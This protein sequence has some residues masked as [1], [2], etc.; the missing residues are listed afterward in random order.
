[1]SGRS[2]RVEVSPFV[3]AGIYGSLVVVL[4]IFF[5]ALSLIWSEARYTPEW[6]PGASKTVLD[7][8]KVVVGAIIGVLTPSVVRRGG[9]S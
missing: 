2:G 8:I 5:V 1:M 4:M 9:S 3:I 6:I 7:L